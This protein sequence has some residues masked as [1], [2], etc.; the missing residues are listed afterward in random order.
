[1]SKA[2]IFVWIGVML[3]LTLWP[4][5]A[6][7]DG[8][9]NDFQN[10]DA[11][12]LTV[13]ITKKWGTLLELQNRLQNNWRDESV[14]FIRPSLYY[15]LKPNLIASVGYSWST[16]YSLQTQKF[17]VE[18]RV[19]EQLIYERPL[20][21]H[22]HLSSRTRLEQ[23]FINGASGTGVRLRE[24][25]SIKHP[26]PGLPRSKN[27]LVTRNEFFFNF[28]SV[29]PT[30]QA[31]FDQLRCLFGLGRQFS[32]NTAVEAG[33]MINYVHRVYGPEQLNHV[34]VVYVYHKLSNPLISG[35][36][37]KSTSS[38]EKNR[39]AGVEPA[40]PPEE[41]PLDAVPEPTQPSRQQD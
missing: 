29:S 28:N 26:I 40:S 12:Y 27:Y 8:V 31:G 9:K 21:H 24:M 13:P 32:P 23:R 11:I 35:S 37:A 14:F 41:S 18:N 34:L 4:Q 16:A 36:K 2:P 38:I 1:M 33:Y 7:A 25:I 19:W 22:F 3:S 39:V 15:Y 6:H 17:N 20:K 30:A 10:W 5:L